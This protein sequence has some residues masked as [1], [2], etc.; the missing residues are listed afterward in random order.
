[1]Y[2]KVRLAKICKTNGGIV[3]LSVVQCNRQ[4]RLKTKDL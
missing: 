3:T 1:M 4:K 2:F